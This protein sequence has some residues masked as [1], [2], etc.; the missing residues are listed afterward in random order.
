M[1]SKVDSF[2]SKTQNWVEEIEYLRKICLDCKLTEEIKWGKPCY[3][4]QGNNIAII[5]AF[6]N[7]CAL[8]FFKGVLLKDTENILEK[9]GKNSRIARRFSFTQLEELRKNESRLKNYIFEAIEIEKAGLEVEIDKETEPAPEELL[10]KLKEN[11]S[12][13]KAF[14]A[15]TP[16]RQRAYRLY[17]SAPKQS[18]T[19]ESRIEKCIPKILE[20]KG[21]NER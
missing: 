10:Q 12:L 3:S 5:Q 2:I 7:S 13:K 14:D 15:L 18:K 8:M 4:F 19:R 11:H 21:P 16:G 17:F 1:N 9:P 6:K 20:G